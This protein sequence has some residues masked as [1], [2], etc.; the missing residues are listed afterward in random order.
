MLIQVV[1][2]LGAM[3]VLGAYAMIQGGLWRELDRGYLALNILGSLMLGVVAIL[4]RQIGF[5]LLEFAWMGLAMWGVIRALS[6]RE[7]M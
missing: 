4:E 3:M 7:K 1:S 2:I 5:V 6:V